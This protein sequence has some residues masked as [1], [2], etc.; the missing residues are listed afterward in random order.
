MRERHGTRVSSRR[1][2]RWSYGGLCGAVL[3]VVGCTTTIDAPGGANDDGYGGGSAGSA[4]EG[5]TAGTSGMT[6]TGGAGTSGSGSTAG[7]AGTAGEP[8]LPPDAVDQACAAM[9][10]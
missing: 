9:N 1:A 10:G 4:T 8:P 3:G 7:T 5:G 2:A 6:G